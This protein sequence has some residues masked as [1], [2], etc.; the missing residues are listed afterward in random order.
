MKTFSL[1]VFTII[2]MFTACSPRPEIG[3]A[4]PI[5]VT[6][7]AVTPIVGTALPAVI[8]GLP[9]EATPLPSP[10]ATPLPTL[11]S[12][13]APSALK[14]KVLEQFP[15]LFFCD[16][17]LYPVA[18]AD[19]MELA[20][21]RFPELQANQEE[22]QAVLEQFGL[23]GLA[24]FS[25]E[26]KLRIYQEHK[27]L[28]AILFEP[29]GEGYRFQLQIV[30]SEGQA[31]GGMGQGLIITGLID[32]RGSITVQERQPSI[33]DCP[34]CLAAGT[35]IDTPHGPV[36][37]EEL[38]VGDFVWTAD[39]TGRRIAARLLK[40]SR[41]IAP[42]THAMA[43]IVLDNGREL[44]ASP[45]H[46][47]ADGRRA[48]ELVVGDALDGGHVMR[49]E[50]LPYDQPAAYDVLPEGITGW[51]WANGILMGSALAR[52]EPPGQVCASDSQ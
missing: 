19:E 38:R 5:S 24:D 31:P 16:P 21:Q 34:I 42:P 25:A 9:G 39:Q 7:F 47:T 18:R 11:P 2:A 35:T 1:F 43:H 36:A 45:G 14:Y 40:T 17:D 12:G 48:G 32:G 50:R 22:F 29:A 15:N 26:Q 51:Y 23:A 46:P 41:A 30:E 52:G 37:V 49:V 20:Q 27:R 3:E 4:T 6:G 28:A 33:A 13:A 8:S 10:T 44:W